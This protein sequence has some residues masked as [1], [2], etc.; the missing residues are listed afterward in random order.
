[1]LILCVSLLI[2]IMGRRAVGGSGAGFAVTYLLLEL[3]QLLRAKAAYRAQEASHRPRLLLD[4]LANV[5]G[6]LAGE[7]QQLV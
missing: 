1:M 3:T 2:L 7:R 6:H 4:D 5:R